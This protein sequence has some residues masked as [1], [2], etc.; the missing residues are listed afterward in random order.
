MSMADYTV[1][2]RVNPDVNDLQHDHAQ[3]LL[4]RDLIF[5]TS[6]MLGIIRASFVGFPK[7]FL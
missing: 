7:K 6:K 2:K 4:L 1:G 5:T 3:V